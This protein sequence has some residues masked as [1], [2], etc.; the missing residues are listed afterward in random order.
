M[1]HTSVNPLRGMLSALRAARQQSQESA[2]ESG[3][4][5]LL[6]NVDFVPAGLQG[7]QTASTGDGMYADLP[8]LEHDAG[9]STSRST[10]VTSTQQSPESTVDES[11]DSEDDLPVLEASSSSSSP[12]PTQGFHSPNIRVSVTSNS[13]TSEAMQSDV[14]IPASGSPHPSTRLSARSDLSRVP[15][16]PR[17]SSALEELDDGAESDSSMPSLFTVSASSDGDDD[18]DDT[19]PEWDG[20]DEYDGVDDSEDNHFDDNVPLTL[21]PLSPPSVSGAGVRVLDRQ[22]ML[23]SAANGFGEISQMLNDL[24]ERML[25]VGDSLVEPRIYDAGDITRAE[26][27]LA[28]LEEVSDDMVRRY[29][30]LRRTE[31]EDGDG[32]AICRDD[33]IDSSIPIEPVGEAAQIISLYAALPFHHAANPVVAFSCAGKHLYHSECITPWLSCKTTCPS[34]RFDIDPHSLTLKKNREGPNAGMDFWGRPSRIWQPPQMESMSEWLDGE[35]RARSCGVPRMRPQPVMQTPGPAPVTPPMQ[36]DPP[37][38]EDYLDAPSFSFA[39][40]D[41]VDSG[42]RLS[43]L[44]DELTHPR[45]P[46]VVIPPEIIAQIAEARTHSSSVVITM[47]PAD[48]QPGMIDVMQYLTTQLQTLVQ[49][50]FAATPMTFE[51]LA[52]GL[53][54]ALHPASTVPYTLPEALGTHTVIS[55]QPLAPPPPPDYNH[56]NQDVLPHAPN[57]GEAHPPIQIQI[58]LHIEASPAAEGNFMNAMASAGLG[59]HEADDS[60]QAVSNWAEELD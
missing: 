58:D 38:F 54:A 60:S 27:L 9:P 48:P 55:T 23:T 13:T 17:V 16:S 19:D 51:D 24:L 21:A 32:C 22:S 59:V 5:G 6:Q 37:T 43:G 52:S 33:L 28:G 35:E 4:I 8:S 56:A 45:D 49:S 36:Q 53:Q 42:E 1:D 34:C 39:H 40:D 50:T 11:S 15:S 10:C 3:L 14:V 57:A 29:E 12:L 46:E 44:A 47:P 18:Y 25:S 20:S 2:P 31:G 41:E 7:D 30:K 26:V